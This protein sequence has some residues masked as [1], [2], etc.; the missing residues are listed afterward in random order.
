MPKGCRDIR[1]TDQWLYL[2]TVL[3]TAVYFDLAFHVQCIF[4]LQRHSQKG[5]LMHYVWIGL[6]MWYRLLMCKIPL[7]FHRDHPSLWPCQWLCKCYVNLSVNLLI[8][9]STL[10]LLGPVTQSRA[11]DCTIDNFVQSISK[12]QLSDRLL[13]FVLRNPAAKV[14]SA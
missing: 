13:S 4:M 9:W 7:M 11:I 14:F 3:F 8:S 6:W 10:K 1:Y 12:S 2:G 5:G